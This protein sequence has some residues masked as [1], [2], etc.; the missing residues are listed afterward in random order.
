MIVALTLLC[1]NGDP[2]GAMELDDLVRRYDVVR[3]SEPATG[4]ETIKA[5]GMTIILAPGLDIALVNGQARKLAQPVELRDGRIVVPA[6]IVAS[7]DVVAVRRPGAR[8]VAK[9][10]PSKKNF[11]VVLDPGHGWMDT[12][13][14]GRNGLMEKD[15]TLDVSR[16]LQKLLE[17][18]GIEVVTTRADARE[19]EIGKREDLEKRVNVANAARADLFLSIHSNYHPTPDPRGFELWIPRVLSG[20]AG[21][22]TIAEEI[23][24]QFRA[25]LDTEDR[26]IKQKEG[27][28]E[29]IS[30]AKGEREL[31]SPAHRQKLAELLFASVKSYAA[32]R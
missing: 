32:K 24:K 16:R 5:A 10:K 15:V 20:R 11:K 31:G 22:R 29:F 1:L 30:N 21:S 26:G 4:R 2:P 6:E 23:Q 17:E 3:T 7:L 12:G 18:Y 14:K 9:A 13:G 8:D 28:T 25:N 27:R 19:L